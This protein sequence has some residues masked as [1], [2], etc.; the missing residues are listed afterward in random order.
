MITGDKSLSKDA[1][2]T[3]NAP[4]AIGPYSQAIRAGY[5]V[6]LSGQIGLDPA[7]GNLV[8]GVE[9]QAHRALQNLRAVAEAAGGELDDVVKL[10]LLLADMGDFPKV[11][12]IMASYFRPPY[13]ARATFQAAALPKAARVEI[14]AVLA[15]R[16]V[17]PALSATGWREA[18]DDTKS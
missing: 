5:T 15:L 1:I 12:E 9:A 18:F 3:P 4:A 10:T 16:P 14:E 7:T 8:D 6:Y 11:N 13:P 2:H 17:S